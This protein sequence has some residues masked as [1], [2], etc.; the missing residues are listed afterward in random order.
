MKFLEKYIKEYEHIII[1]KD[2]V[3]GDITIEIGKIRNK[4]LN[5]TEY[6]FQTDDLVKDRKIAEAQRQCYYQFIVDLKHIKETL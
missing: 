5:T 3:I 2:R 6:N 1:L 4:S